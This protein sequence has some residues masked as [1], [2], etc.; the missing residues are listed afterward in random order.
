MEGRRFKVARVQVPRS[1]TRGSFT[2]TVVH[3]PL[4]RVGKYSEPS[5]AQF[6]PRLDLASPAPNINAPATA[7]IAADIQLVAT[8]LGIFVM[9]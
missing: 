9:F 2:P 8:G 6:R 7:E 4:F 1:V 3:L 5:V